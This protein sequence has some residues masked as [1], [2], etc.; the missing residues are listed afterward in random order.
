MMTDQQLFDYLSGDLTADEISEVEKWIA[1][2]EKNKQYF[3][4]FR[5]DYLKWGWGMRAGLVQGKWEVVRSRL[6]FRK[7]MRLSRWAAVIALILG[8][9][10]LLYTRSDR[11][12]KETESLVQEVVPGKSQAVLILS[13][14]E[15]VALTTASHELCEEDGTAIQID[16]GGRVRYKVGNNRPEQPALF[17]RIVIPR[18]G[19]YAMQL[20][21]GTQVWLN[22]ATELR[23]PVAFA[24]DR[25]VVYL[26]GEAYFK[27]KA[28]SA[29][30][31]LVMA[32]EV[33]VKV[34][35]T[36]FNVNNYHASQV[37]AVLVK[38]K[39]GMNHG[40]Q[41]IRLKPGEKGTYLAAG[42]AMPIEEVDV[43][44]YIAWKEGNF[45]FD[46]ERLEEIMEK[47]ARWYDIEVFYARPEVK[48]I[49][50]SGDMRRYKD[51]QALL[52]YFEQISGVR[53]ALNGKTITIK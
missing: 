43:A 39:I 9:G 18:G 7:R 1:A 10:I 19:E 8:S 40:T 36:E 14:G 28:D 49:R 21:D 4:Q 6:R 31:F 34:Y 51:I 42:Q 12:G 3:G 33:G 22:A 16:S 38:G 53:F 35:G 52:Y 24:K 44:S 25:R 5:N 20:E 48:G 23:Y 45:V 2:D 30:P 17:N 11:F 46:N 50:L 41:E 37:E 27:V 13:T 29:R 15:K 47:L 32:D 26:K